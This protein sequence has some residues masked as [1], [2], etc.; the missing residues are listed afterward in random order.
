MRLAAVANEARFGL[1]RNIMGFIDRAPDRGGQ[2]ARPG[3]PVL[4]QPLE[5]RNSSFGLTICRIE[6]EFLE[7]LDELD[8]VPNANRNAPALS[9]SSR[10]RLPRAGLRKIVRPS[11]GEDPPFVAATGGA[12]SSAAASFS[13]PRPLPTVRVAGWHARLVGVEAG[14]GGLDPIGEFLFPPVESK[15]PFQAQQGRVS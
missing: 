11:V 10:L 1:Q 6:F 9:R 5:L 4:L 2:P 12:A 8:F 15:P 13:D 7:R 14:L 3:L